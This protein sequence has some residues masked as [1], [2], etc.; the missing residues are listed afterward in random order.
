[1]SWKTRSRSE[2][3]ARSGCERGKQGAVAGEENT[4]EPWHKQKEQSES[5]RASKERTHLGTKLERPDK[6]QDVL[7][8]GKDR[9]LALERVLPEEEVKGGRRVLEAI[10][11]VCTRKGCQL[12]WL[13]APY[14]GHA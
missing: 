11:P 9:V 1:M 2:D 13:F 12:H 3:G 4:T 6:A 8:T 10:L 14:H 7:E 5:A